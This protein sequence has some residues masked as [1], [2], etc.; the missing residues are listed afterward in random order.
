MDKP[1]FSFN[2]EE[3]FIL[4]NFITVHNGKS[5]F[6]CKKDDSTIDLLGTKSKKVILKKSSETAFD[7]EIS[8]GVQVIAHIHWQ[9]SLVQLL[10]RMEAELFNDSL[11]IK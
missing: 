7:V 3:K 9:A 10:M 4:D 8:S 6:A 5:W 1:N 2:A 11:V